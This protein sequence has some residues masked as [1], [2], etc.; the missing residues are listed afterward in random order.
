[1]RH[2]AVQGCGA[3]GRAMPRYVGR[4]AGLDHAVPVVPVGVDGGRAAQRHP[5]GL[6][7][8]GAE[9]DAGRGPARE[10]H[11]VGV[12]DRVGQPAHPRHHGHGA[13]AQR[14]ELRQSAG[15]EAR[16][17]QQRVAA[18]LDEV[19]QGLV[20]ADADADPPRVLGRGGPERVLHP[21]LARA[22][23][24]E[25]RLDVEQGWN[26]G[27]EEVEPFLVRQPA[28]DAEQETVGHRLNP[29]RVLQGPLVGASSGQRPGPVGMR[30]QGV[31]GGVPHR[32]VDAVADAGEVMGAGPQQAVE[33]HAVLGRQDLGRVGGRHGGDTVGVDEPGLQEAD[34]VVVFEARGRE[35]LPGEAEPRQDVGREQAWESHVVD[36]EHGADPRRLAEPQIGGGQ[37]RLPVVR[38]EN[39]GLD[40]GHQPGREVGGHAAQGREPEGIVGPV[41]PV[42][43]HVGIAVAVEQVGR[44][45]HEHVQTRHARREEPRRAAE[46]GGV[47]VQRLGIP[48]SLEHRRVAGQQRPHPHAQGGQRTRQRPGNVG[49][50]AR[51]DQRVDLGGDRKNLQVGQARLSERGCRSSAA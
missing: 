5:Q 12:H 11:L 45:D 21:P 39:V 47:L 41:G 3:L 29:E 46:Q 9:L 13:V 44:V 38:L 14:A 17:H 51:L 37:P 18:G 19:G 49:Q 16:R 34:L 15:L 24:H 4:H 22:E 27:E 10:R 2:G 25:L 50:P 32:L 43:G 35:G 20:V 40:A 36:R 28:D 7:R 23:Q 31:G 33:A 6:G 42:R 48:Q 1:M 30:Q 26:R 8:D